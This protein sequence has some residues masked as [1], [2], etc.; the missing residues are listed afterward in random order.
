[1]AQV[2]EALGFTRQTFYAQARAGNPGVVY[3][4]RRCMRNG[5]GRGFRRR[6][7]AADVAKAQSLM[8]AGAR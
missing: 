8:I 6:W 4:L 1:M 2:C 7:L 3:L 5:T